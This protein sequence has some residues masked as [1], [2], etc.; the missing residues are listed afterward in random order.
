MDDEGRLAGDLPCLCCGYNLR[1][2]PAESRCPECGAAV[3]RSVY[4]NK[5]AYCE[6]SWLTAVARGTN[7]LVY[8]LILRIVFNIVSMV[9][10]V[11]L[12]MGGAYSAAVGYAFWGA[13]I[14]LGVILAIGCWMATSFDPALGKQEN[15][16]SARRIA[17]GALIATV[18]LGAIDNLLN[19]AGF[20]A[21]QVQLFLHSGVS[22]ASL[23][24]YLI[25]TGAFL[26][27]ARSM[28]L[29]I[30]DQA[31]ASKLR[32]ATWGWPISVGVYLAGMQIMTLNAATQIMPAALAT[33]LWG[34]ARLAAIPALVFGLWT[35]SLLSKYRKALLATAAQARSSWAQ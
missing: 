17:R 18:L 9:I 16:Y 3:G 2:L 24:S 12:G 7:L 33:A 19:L 22:F 4:G 11:A 15:M 20:G 13:S 5:L 35:L 23:I 14:L 30:P 28:A 29:R 21:T 31:M 8:A 27:H 32:L 1:G 26:Q 34:I 10:F 25:C 6:P